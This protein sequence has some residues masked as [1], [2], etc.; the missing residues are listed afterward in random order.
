MKRFYCM[1]IQHFTKNSL[2]HTSKAN[3]APPS[4]FLWLLLVVWLSYTGPMMW[5]LKVFNPA[6]QYIC[7]TLKNASDLAVN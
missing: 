1:L 5:K 4:I 3:A 6:N 2:T 7:T